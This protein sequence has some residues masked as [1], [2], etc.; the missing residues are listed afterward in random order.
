[1]S[2]GELTLVH[3]VPGEA[4]FPVDITV[5]GRYFGFSQ[6]FEGVTFGTVAPVEVPF[7]RY[8]VAIRAAGADPESKPVL[9]TRTWVGFR[10]KAVVAHL[11]GDGSPMVSKF[12]NTTV[13]HHCN[14]LLKYFGSGDDMQVDCVLFNQLFGYKDA[15]SKS[16]GNWC[17]CDDKPKLRNSAAAFSVMGALGGM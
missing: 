4:D 3:G 6:T 13:L 11:D 16:I 5:T 17:V 10:D 12:D 14:Q 9:K 8:T 15:T 2:G 1:M 7:D